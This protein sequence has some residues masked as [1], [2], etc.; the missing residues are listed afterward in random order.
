MYD[1]NAKETKNERKKR[2]T[3]KRQLKCNIDL[4][5]YFV[6]RTSEN[7]NFVEPNNKHLN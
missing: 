1:S 2:N 6:S 4:F 3:I 7:M 5:Q